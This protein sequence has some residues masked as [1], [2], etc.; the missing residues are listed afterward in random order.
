MSAKRMNGKRDQRTKRT[1][2]WKVTLLP[3]GSIDGAKGEAQV[4]C[5]RLDREVGVR[6][7]IGDGWV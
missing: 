4:Y 2:M 6:W 3:S 1:R 5:S 7:D